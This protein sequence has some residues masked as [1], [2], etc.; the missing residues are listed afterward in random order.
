MRISMMLAAA[1]LT[2]APLVAAAPPPASTVS[3]ASGESIVVRVDSDGAVTA[4][5]PVPAPPLTD[6]DAYSLGKIASTEVPQD[7]K[8][9]AP[10]FTLKGEGPPPTRIARGQIRFTFRDVAGRTPH[11]ALLTIE[12]GYRQGLTYTAVIGLGGRSK[13]TDVCLVLPG[14][15]GYEHWPFPLDRIELANLRLRPWREGDA[16]TCR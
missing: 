2:A 8:V 15:R 5:A 12:N 9:L 11:E 4:A 14:K 1:A 13:P 10:A 7:A 6:L 16:V 3:L